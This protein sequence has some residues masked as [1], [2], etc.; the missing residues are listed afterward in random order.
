MTMLKIVTKI[1]NTHGLGVCGLAI[2]LS[3]MN[4]DKLSDFQN[5]V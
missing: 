1:K 2:K 5:T 4:L 3:F